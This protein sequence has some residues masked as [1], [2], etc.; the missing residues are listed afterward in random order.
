MD[1]ESVKTAVI[2]SVPA[3]ESVA[4]GRCRVSRRQLFIVIVLALGIVL[5]VVSSFAVGFYAGIHKA[6]FSYRFSENYERNFVRSEQMKGKM[7]R[8]MDGKS[9][10]SGHGVSGEVLSIV[11]RTIVLRNQDGQEN[12]ITVTD[13]TVYNKG[14]DRVDLEA[15]LVGDRIVVLGKPGDDGTVNADLIRVLGADL[16]RSDGSLRKLFR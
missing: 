8:E 2:S 9:F 6:R 3:T 1:S 14:G 11:D 13:A 15:V 16:G 12:S 7:F 4:A 5:L 10:R